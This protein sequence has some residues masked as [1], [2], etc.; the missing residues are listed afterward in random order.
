MSTIK[1]KVRKFGENIDTDTSRAC[2]VS[3]ASGR[4]DGEVCFWSC[5]G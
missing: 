3:S 4:R 5:C 1:G 2:S